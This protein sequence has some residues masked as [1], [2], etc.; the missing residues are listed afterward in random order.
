M[1]WPIKG[2]LANRQ[3][4]ETQLAVMR[5]CAATKNNMIIVDPAGSNAEWCAV[6]RLTARGLMERKRFG[7]DD[8]GWVTTYGLTQRGIDKLISELHK[9]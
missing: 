9:I 3:V 4:G 8:I 5:R 6:K 2:S 7:G 1:A